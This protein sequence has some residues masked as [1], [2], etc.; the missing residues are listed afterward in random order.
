MIN[1]FYR[2]R[3][4]PSNRPEYSL[5]L[6]NYYNQVLKFVTKGFTDTTPEKDKT[7]ETTLA[8]FCTEEDIYH[9]HS[10][11]TTASSNNFFR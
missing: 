5:F 6:P 3:L 2:L 8:T 9:C 7:H 11:C 1:Y 4:Q 10:R